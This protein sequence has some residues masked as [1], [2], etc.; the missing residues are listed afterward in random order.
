MPE[1]PVKYFFQKKH[2]KIEQIPDKCGNNCAYAALPKG[3]DYLQY[4]FERLPNLKDENDL[5]NLLPVNAQ[6]YL[7]KVKRID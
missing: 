5:L 2:Q 4:L 6:Q 3:H 7:P 1:N